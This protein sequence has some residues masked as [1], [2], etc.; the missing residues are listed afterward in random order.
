MRRWHSAPGGGGG[1]SGSESESDEEDM[2]EEEDQEAEGNF[3]FAC[4]RTPAFFFLNRFVLIE[5]LMRP[6]RCAK[7]GNHHIR[8][9]PSLGFTNLLAK[10]VE[11][12]IFQPSIT[13]YQNYLPSPKS[14]AKLVASRIIDSRNYVSRSA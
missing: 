11:D 13:N 1:A 3:A 14:V 6:M 7:A 2:A 8:I 5:Q 9:H 12:Y 10:R 4:A